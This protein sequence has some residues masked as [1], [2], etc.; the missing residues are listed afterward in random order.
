MVNQQH[1]FSRSLL[2]KAISV[3]LVLTILLS[4]VIIGNVFGT[5]AFAAEGDYTYSVLSDGTAKITKY[6]GTDS[7]VTVPAALGGVNV[8]EIGEKAFQDNDEIESVIISDGIKTIGTS[9][10]ADCDMLESIEFS[11][12]V[13]TIGKEAFRNCRGLQAV[14]I[15]STVKTIEEKAFSACPILGTVTLHEGLE[16][17]GSRFIAGTVVSEIYIPTTVTNSNESFAET[18]LLETVIFG[19]GITEIPRDMFEENNSLRTLTIPDT[20][21][22]I[23]DDAFCLMKSLESIE[24]P[25]NVTELGTYICYQDP[26]LTKVTFGSGRLPSEAD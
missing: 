16:K 10:F 19:E 5:A 6:S 15:P 12:S 1:H 18:E 8:S 25:D 23:G 14:D 20:V 3:T 13:E 17:M 9:A 24:F 7:N 21:T 26:K 2:K 4:M 11:P 22:K